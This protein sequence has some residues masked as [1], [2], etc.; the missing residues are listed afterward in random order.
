MSDDLWQTAVDLSTRLPGRGKRSVRVTRCE[1]GEYV[2][3][4]C[5]STTTG[6]GVEECAAGLGR[7]ADAALSALAVRLREVTA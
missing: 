6:E 2:A 5:V 7:S 3:T 1:S 4:A